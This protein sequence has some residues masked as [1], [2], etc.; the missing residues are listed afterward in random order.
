MYLM[1][2][3][4]LDLVDSIERTSFRTRKSIDERG[5][6]GQ[7][8]DYNSIKRGMGGSKLHIQ[9]V[10]WEFPHRNRNRKVSK[11][12]DW[13]LRGQQGIWTVFA[14]S[15]SLLPDQR[16]WFW[17]TLW[18]EELHDSWLLENHLAANGVSKGCSCPRLQ[19]PLHGLQYSCLLFVWY[20]LFII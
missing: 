18:F 15:S 1:I 6:G 5:N 8:G 9:L 4:I 12:C 10:S 13:G 20:F 14:S 19:L 3:A 11:T 16:H 2:H 17:P 7:D